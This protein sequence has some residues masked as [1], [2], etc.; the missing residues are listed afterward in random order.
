MSNNFT[1]IEEVDGCIFKSKYTSTK[2]KV[3]IEYAS[4]Y[5][6]IIDEDG[7]LGPYFYWSNNFTSILHIL[8]YEY[9]YVSGPEQPLNKTNKKLLTPVERKI[10]K[11]YD[12][13]KDR[14]P[15]LAQ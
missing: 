11:I 13:Q 3:H 2:F 12:K 5:Y 4:V 10:R 8:N 1:R 15:F 9:I 6:S 14:F 7:G